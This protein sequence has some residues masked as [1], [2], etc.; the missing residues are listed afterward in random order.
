MNLVHID[1]HSKLRKDLTSGGVVNVDVNMYKQHK[2][3]REAALRQIEERKALSQNVNTTQD[4]I[5]ELKQDVSDIKSLLLQILNK[6][7]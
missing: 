1:G 6:Q 5:N 2:V 3:N 4:Q 7:G